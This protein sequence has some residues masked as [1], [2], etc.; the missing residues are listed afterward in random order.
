MKRRLYPLQHYSE[1]GDL[2]SPP[3]LLYILLFLSRT[4]MLLII[5]VASFETGNKLLPIF[6]P[7]KLHFYL[8]LIIG[9]LP[10]VIFA[11][12]GRRHAQDKW[13]LRF[14]PYCLYLLIISAMG[15]LGFQLYYL[16]LEHFEYSIT[17]SIQL[18]I[19]AWI[20]IYFIKSKHLIDCFKRTH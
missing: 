4:W 5:S 9:F 3:L 2:K 13:A 16:Y 14:W 15:D 7:D 19:T 6:Y 18:V 8:G 1:S 12:S 10:I 11:V 17:A 20:C